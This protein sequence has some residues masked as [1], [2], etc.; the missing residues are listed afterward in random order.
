MPARAMTTTSIKP[1]YT[2]DASTRY[3]KKV[4]DPYEAADFCTT[5]LMHAM[6]RDQAMAL[7]ATAV[8]KQHHSLAKRMGD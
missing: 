6:I 5:K 4:Q 1:S 3:E 7:T 8:R 2:R